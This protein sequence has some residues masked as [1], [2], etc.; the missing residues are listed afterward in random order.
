MVNALPKN[1]DAKPIERMFLTLKN[2]FSRIVETFCGGTV[3][4]RKESLKYLLKNG[5]ISS[6]I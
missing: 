5:I 1:A 6:F 2:Q 3:V 4:E